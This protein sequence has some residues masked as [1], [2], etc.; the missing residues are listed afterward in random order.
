MK[1]P[2]VLKMLGAGVFRLHFSQFGEDVILHK[3]FGRKFSNG[4]Y[5]DI[6]A[7]H[8]F[9]QSNTAYLWMM[10]WRGINVDASQTSIAA[11][12]KTRTGDVNIWSAVVDPATAAGKTEI[13]LFSSQD[14][15]LCATCD[16]QLANERGASRSTLVPCTTLKSII[17]DRAAKLTKSI[18]VMNIDIEGFDQA[19]IADMAEWTIK[20][21]VI[22][23]E[24]YENSVR[25]VLA[26]PACALL[27]GFG[28]VMICRVGPTAIFELR[29]A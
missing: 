26:S 17:N 23:I 10:G 2:R 15:D 20:P 8:P 1:F 9:R 12:N 4:F 27:E 7:H 6:G 3:L 13:E 22:C 18:E 5:V 14:L 11:F 21:K 25:E 19:A 29:T 16:P 24:I 28:Y